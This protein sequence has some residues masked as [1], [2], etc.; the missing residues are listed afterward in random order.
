MR[1]CGFASIINIIVHFETMNQLAYL[2]GMI[3]FLI[4]MIG[5]LVN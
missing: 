2:I 1:V 3:G 4:E 5:A